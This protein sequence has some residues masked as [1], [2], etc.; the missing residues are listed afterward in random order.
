MPRAAVSLP[1]AL[2]ALATPSL[3]HAD[4]PDP[5]FARDKALHFVAGGTL[6]AGGYGLGAA[7]FRERAPAFALGA[8]VGIGASAAKEAWDLTGRGDPSWRDFTWGAIGTVAGLALAW[9]ID[10][11]VHGGKPPPLFASGAA[12]RF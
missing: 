4:D 10:V 7:L 9:G 8:G 1:L 11:A 6:A 3:A 2:L 12:I 5:W